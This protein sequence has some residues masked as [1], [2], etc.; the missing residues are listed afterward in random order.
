MTAALVL[1]PTPGIRR[2][3]VGDGEAGDVA[4]VGGNGPLAVAVA[5]P[6]VP[7]RR[8][9]CGD[10]AAADIDRPRCG[11][12]PDG[13]LRHPGRPLSSELDPAGRRVVPAVPGRLGPPVVG[14]LG[15]GHAHEGYAVPRAAVRT[16]T[17]SR[18]SP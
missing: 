1:R 4:A 6:H 15:E 14:E 13:M 9:L 7:V 3:A 5:R 18:A 17:G 16:P 2:G 12:Q 11:R 10:G 8:R